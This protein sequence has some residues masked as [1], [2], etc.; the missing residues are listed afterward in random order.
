MTETVHQQA[1]EAAYAQAVAQGMSEEA[2]EIAAGAAAGQFADRYVAEHVTPS[3]VNH[4]ILESAGL[5]DMVT[6]PL[7]QFFDAYGAWDLAPDDVLAP[8]MPVTLASLIDYQLNVSTGLVSYDSSDPSSPANGT[9]MQLMVIVRDEPMS[10]TSMDSIAGARDVMSQFA[11]EN[12]WVVGTWVLGTGAVLYDISDVVNSEFH[13]IELGVVVLIYILLLLVLGV[14]FTPIRSLATIL[15]SVVWTLG[16]LHLVFVNVLG[17]DVIWI[18]PIVLFVICLGLGMDYDILL[19]TRIREGK[20]RG[21]SNDEAIQSAVSWSGSV[22]TLCGLVMGGTFLTL[23][24]SGSSML[25]EIG[26]ALGFAILVDAL[27]VVPYVVPAL[28][29][30]MGDW[31][32]K[33][34]RFLERRRSPVTRDEESR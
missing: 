11:G 20:L 8:T 16:V 15:M 4:A 23:L 32:W 9:Y 1:Y 19:T 24:T 12:D 30:L 5:P 25:Q 7:K 29:H 14:Y 22:I 28:M 31:S 21:M 33:G 26:F 13:W 34:P 6:A 18:V 17:V 27:F 10:Q 3:V 2:A